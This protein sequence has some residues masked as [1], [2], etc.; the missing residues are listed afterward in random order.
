MDWTLILSAF[1]ILMTAL[2]SW[3]KTKDSKRFRLIET[4]LTITQ[5][6]LHEAQKDLKECM[7]RDASWKIRH[8]GLQDE[9]TRLDMQRN[10]LMTKV[11]ELQDKVNELTKYPKR[12]SS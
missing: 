5:D 7:E 12:R 9:I 2:F 6:E 1:T 4:Q 11:I 10:G 3:M 8:Q